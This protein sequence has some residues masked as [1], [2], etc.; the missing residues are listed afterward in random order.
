MPTISPCLWFDNEAEDA[1]NLYV[2]IFPNSTVTNV[3]RYPDD[4]PNL[5]GT[6]LAVNFVLDGLRF[7][8]INGG[9]SANF[10]E[11]VSFSV[12]A[13]TQEEIDAYWN[14]LTGDGGEPGRCGWLTDRFGLSW[15]VV[16]PRLGE[17]LADPERGGRVM[18]VMMGQSKIVIS[19]LE[20]A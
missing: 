3:A 15:Q 13:E 1:A 17:L 10:T 12:P 20:A 8:A 11:A 18:Q 5:A 19:E 2:S 14:A 6:V 9:P 7:Q 4:A 16:P